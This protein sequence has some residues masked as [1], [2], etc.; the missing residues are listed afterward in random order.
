M[1]K[2]IIFTAAALATLSAYAE[3]KPSTTDTLVVTTSPQ[4]HC[5][6]CE[7]KIKQNIRFVKGTKKISTSVPDQT[8]TIVYDNRKCK[9]EDYVEAFEKIGYDI[10]KAEKKEE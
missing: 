3:K 6:S 7:T 10:K 4:M 8:V 1:K 5:N 2:T 9:Y